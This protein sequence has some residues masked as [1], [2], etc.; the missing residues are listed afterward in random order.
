[1][2]VQTDHETAVQILDALGSVRDRSVRT[3]HVTP[4]FTK[5]WLWMPLFLTA[6]MGV[7]TFVFVGGA[8]YGLSVSIASLVALAALGSLLRPAR[9][10]IRDDAIQLSWMW[11]RWR[12]PPSEVATV[13][14]KSSVLIL[15]LRSNERRRIPLPSTDAG[16]LGLRAEREADNIHALAR[17]CVERARSA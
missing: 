13:A 15:T 12:V 1:L 4:L 11:Q 3:F 16:P 17:E 7:L 8:I 14:R 6:F 2:A 9:V 5:S 10:A